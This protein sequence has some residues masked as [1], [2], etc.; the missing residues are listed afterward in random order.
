MIEQSEALNLS[1]LEAGGSTE[2]KSSA[3]AGRCGLTGPPA[4]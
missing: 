2:V 3:V 4:I 1:K